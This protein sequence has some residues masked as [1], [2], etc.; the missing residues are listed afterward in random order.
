M[1]MHR[2]LGI[3][4]RKFMIRL[5][6]G[7]VLCVAGMGD[8]QSPSLHAQE[9]TPVIPTPASSPKAPASE[10][11]EKAIVVARL[12]DA[13]QFFRVG[14]FDKAIDSYNNIISAGTDDAAAYAGLVRVYLKLKKPDQAYSAA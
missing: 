8:W 6:I 2:H 7:L 3:S 4:C 14:K 9:P 11:K 12:E 5:V 10:I 13:Q 1:E